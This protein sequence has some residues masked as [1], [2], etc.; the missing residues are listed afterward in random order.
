MSDNL[1]LFIEG[2]SGVRN[3]HTYRLSENPFEYKEFTYQLSGIG[4]EPLVS[5]NSTHVGYQSGQFI[6]IFNSEL[7]LVQKLSTSPIGNDPES[8]SL[9]EGGTNI[10]AKFNNRL[11]IWVTGECKDGSQNVDGVCGGDGGGLST[12]AIIGIVVGAVGGVGVIG[13]GGFFLWKKFG[14]RTKSNVHKNPLI[15]EED[16][17]EEV[18]NKS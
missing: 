16:G 7:A 10:Y 8:V 11:H 6:Y 1:V 14:V 13:V 15:E 4:K 17:K 18:M 3:L 12:G 2:T 9:S 5:Y